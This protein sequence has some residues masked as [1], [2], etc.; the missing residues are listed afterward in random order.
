[1]RNELITEASKLFPT[2]D[3]WQGFLELSAQTTAIKEFW[4][5]EATTRIR[6]H[7]MK[8]M[9]P[10]WGLEAFSSTHQ[11]TR[12]FLQKYGPDSLA[13]SFAW[14]YRLDLR[15]WNTQKFSTKPV[16]DALMTSEFGAIHLAFDRIDRQGEWGA[17]LIE[18]GNYSF[19]SSGSGQLTEA[20]LAWYAAHE[21]DSFVA[22]A[23][24]RIERFTS[25]AEVTKALGRLNELAHAEAQA[26]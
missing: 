7:F 12:W 15:I 22:Q 4:F 24:Q 11:D 18:I 6:R 2:I 9:N 10:E 26:H 21:T 16:T 23:I 13:L 25:S 17:E 1:M 14:S 8:N 20:E 3:H 19:E 5:T